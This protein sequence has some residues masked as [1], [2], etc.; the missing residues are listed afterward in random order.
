[1]LNLE[2]IEKIE[3][4]IMEFKARTDD[5]DSKLKNFEDLL[6]LFQKLKPD[7]FTKDI[8]ANIKNDEKFF[9]EFVEFLKRDKGKRE[10]ILVITKKNL[11]DG[12]KDIKF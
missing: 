6:S 8:I 10:T 9:L 11:L 3:K 12:C 4:E 1:M 7:S 2:E 5:L